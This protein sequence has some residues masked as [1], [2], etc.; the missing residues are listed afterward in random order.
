[1][2]DLHTASFFVPTVAELPTRR[3]TVQLARRVAPRL[4]EGALWLLAGEL[5][6]GKTFFVRALLRA[7]G[8]PA[9][10]A[11]SSPTF[12]LVH[13]WETRIG[14]VYHADLYRLRDAGR[15][16]EISA[17]GLSDARREGGRLLVEW[18]DGFEAALAGPASG[19][20]VL[21]RESTPSEPPHRSI[22]LSGPDFEGFV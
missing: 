13:R 9:T 2:S 17:L 22:A 4:G 7:L 18:G 15:L 8:V 14:P 10:E 21:H 11:I 6:A 3:T 20:L 19:R 12:S 16:D 1:V 5:G